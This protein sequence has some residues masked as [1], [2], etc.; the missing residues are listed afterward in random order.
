MD[1]WID[2]W[3]DKWMDGCFAQVVVT[4]RLSI[5][6]ATSKKG[7]SAGRVLYL[8]H[9]ENSDLERLAE[10]WNLDESLPREVLTQTKINK[11]K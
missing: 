9:L 2:K 7:A 6:N 3:N 5:P 11:L 1:R 4:E 10:V 8:E